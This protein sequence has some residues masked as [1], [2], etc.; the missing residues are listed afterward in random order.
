MWVFSNH[1]AICGEKQYFFYVETNLSFVGNGM[2]SRLSEYMRTS[3]SAQILHMMEQT[4]HEHCRL[5][6]PSKDQTVFP[7]ITNVDNLPQTTTLFT[8]EW[9]TNPIRTKGENHSTFVN[10]PE[11]LSPNLANISDH[12][13]RISVEDMAAF[14]SMLLV[15]VEWIQTQEIVSHNLTTR[16]EQQERELADKFSDSRR[17]PPHAT[18]AFPS[19]KPR[20]QHDHGI[21]LQE[22]T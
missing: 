10:W 6:N 19:Y 4:D 17:L 9:P 3:P 7:R 12:M 21:K 11:L 20:V 13:I 1:G 22:S 14:R 18:P 5:L 16:L 15:L 8:L 2:D